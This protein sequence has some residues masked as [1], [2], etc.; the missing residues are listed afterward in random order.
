M[1]KLRLRNHTRFPAC[2][3]LAEEARL[4]R[5]RGKEAAQKK[6]SD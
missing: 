5:K 3:A 4:E 2:Q 6:K 1:P